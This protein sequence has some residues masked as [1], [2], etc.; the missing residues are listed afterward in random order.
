V[1]HGTTLVT[2]AII[3]RKGE[4]TALVTT[5]GFR[6]VLEIRR[7]HRYDMYDLF[8]DPPKEIV[9]RHLRFEVNERI[10]ADGSV[11]EPL[12]AAQVERLATALAAR[13]IRS[14]AVALLHSYR[15]PRHELEIRDIFARCAPEARV[16]LSSEVVNEIKE[17]E[18]TSTTVCNAYVGRIVDEYLAEIARNLEAAGIVAPLHIMLSSGGTATVETSRRFPIRLL[19]SGPAAGALAAAYVGERAGHADLLS[20]DMGGTTAKLCIIEGGRPMRS[21]QLEVDRV[22]RFKKGSGLP[23]KVPVIDM[24]EIGAGGGSIARVDS[25]GLLQVGPD[26]SGADPGP[27]CY[28]RGGRL[29]TVTDADLVLGYLDPGFFLG[30]QMQL[31][32]DAAWR[33]VDTVAVRLGMTVPQA[34]WGIHQ[35]VNENMANAARIHTIDRG[36]NARALPMFAFGGAGPVHAYAVAAILRVPQLILP[37]G[38]GVGSTVGF[39]AAPLSFDFVRTSIERLD[40]IDWQRID[41]LVGGMEDEGIA[42]L[43]AS[44]VA[45]SSIETAL[46]VDLRYVGQGHEVT[47]PIPRAS[48]AADSVNRI[49]REFARAYR[50]LYGRLAEDVPL[51]SVNWRLTVSGPQPAFE[52]RHRPGNSSSSPAKKGERRVYFPEL[53]GFHQTPVYD[54]YALS[55][56]DMLVGPAVVE[57]RESTAVLGP[58]ANGSVDAFANL[59]VRLPV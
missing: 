17:Y 58:G 38:A 2:N 52:L 56:G 34:A 53:S 18:R 16:S 44:G 31:D 13:G 40:G 30:G 24:I 5:A 32:V 29:P 57:E 22:Y 20:F 55:A 36:K 26:S 50:R 14:I 46:A 35:I 11:L 15:N 6:D 43:R 3:E 51:E 9:P 12:D 47:V 1:I 39:L 4:R 45:Q 28:A 59:L 49:T 33:A 41:E 48:L 37:F 25:L 21:S 54:R 7:E 19:E 23:I 10:L 8:I 42:L 27:A